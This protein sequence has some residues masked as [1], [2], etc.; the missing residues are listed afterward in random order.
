LGLPS[1]YACTMSAST[2]FRTRA[3]SPQLTPAEGASCLMHGNGRK[4][5]RSALVVVL[6][7]VAEV[8]PVRAPVAVLAQARATLTART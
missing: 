8:V 4:R 2:I 7:E 6:L 1:S 3:T 5:P